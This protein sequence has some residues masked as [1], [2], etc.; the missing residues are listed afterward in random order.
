M[1]RALDRRD[2]EDAPSS[3]GVRRGLIDLDETAEAAADPTPQPQATWRTPIAW[4]GV[5]FLVGAIFWHFIGFWG[6]VSDIVLNGRGAV[7][8]RYV[9]QTGEDCVS[10]VLDREL[11]AVGAAACPQ[12]APLLNEGAQAVRGDFAG[13]RRR[14]PVAKA[15]DVIRLSN[16]D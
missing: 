1:Q 16:G 14:T 4:A 3:E 12:D 8:E 11:Q 7:D 5:G 9:E 2:D 13:P 10:L 6:F 15:R